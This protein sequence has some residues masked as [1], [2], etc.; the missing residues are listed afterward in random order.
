MLYVSM[1]MNVIFS[2]KL[3]KNNM[4]LFNLFILRKS[5]K[6]DSYFKRTL[7]VPLTKES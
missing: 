7:G 2:S 4:Y 5:S 3:E 1:V 6:G